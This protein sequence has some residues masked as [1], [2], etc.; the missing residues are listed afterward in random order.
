MATR[1]PRD[2]AVA[3][4]KAIKPQGRTRSSAVRGIVKDWLTKAGYLRP[5]A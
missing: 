5:R 2:V 3:L 4:D 1:L